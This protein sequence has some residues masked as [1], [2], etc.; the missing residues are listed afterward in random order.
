MLTHPVNNGL[1]LIEDILVQFEMVGSGELKAPFDS[2]FV[3]ESCI[4][5]IGQHIEKTN[6]PFIFIFFIQETSS[7][8]E[9]K[10]CHCIK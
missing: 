7:N 6:L 10:N 9:P 8:R 5:S 4:V 3:L 1:P 2:M